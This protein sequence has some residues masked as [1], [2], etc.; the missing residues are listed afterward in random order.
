M[1]TR[2]VEKLRE[3]DVIGLNKAHVV[4]HIVQYEISDPLLLHIHIFELL[5][6]QI[7]A[8]ENL[9]DDLFLAVEMIVE[10]SDGYFRITADLLDRGP[11]Q[12]FFREFGHC[13]IIDLILCFQCFLLSVRH[14]FF[15]QSPTPVTVTPL[16][17]IESVPENR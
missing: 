13:R 16:Y 11:L 17:M 6:I 3:S 5:E 2:A 8:S 9:I 1:V 12:A 4:V 10:G 14:L 15:F 7:G